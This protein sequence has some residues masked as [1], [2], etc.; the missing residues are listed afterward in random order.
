MS[1]GRGLTSDQLSG[2][3]TELRG[4]VLDPPDPEFNQRRVPFNAMY[5][6]RPDL[7]VRP[8]GT[9]DVAAAVRYAR[10]HDLEVVV[11]GGGHSVGGLS[12]AD[13]GMVIDL[14]TMHAVDVDPGVRLARVQGGAVLGELDRETQLF[15]LAVPVGVVSQTGVAGL[16]LGGGYGWLRRKHGLACDSLVSAQ[17]VCADG[18]VRT[19]SAEVNPDLFWAIRGGGGNFGVVTS[20]TFELHPV[21]PIVAFA[22]VFYPVEAAAEVLHGYRAYFTDA[23]DEVT[24]EALSITF[25]ADPSLPESVHDRQCLVVGAVYAGAVEEGVA[26]LRPLRELAEPLADI[27]QPMPFTAVQSAFDGLFPRGQIRAYWKAAY[28]ATLEDDVIEI[29]ARASAERP[30]PLTFVDTYAMGGAIARVGADDTAFA[31]RSAPYMVS[32]HGNWSAANDDEANI[33]WVR[34][35]WAKVDA[36]GVGSTYL[37]FSGADDADPSRAAVGFGSNLERLAR[38][39]AQ[40]DPENLFH[41]NNNIAPSGD[42]S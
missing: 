29:V 3:R 18:E 13:G 7:V 41:R 2:F 11:R 24:A 16:P 22:G 40:Y 4:A 27:S 36:L 38:V 14:S 9:A 32:V 26:V 25:P 21:G 17:V 6:D 12:T 42:G 10:E 28:V 31:E 30:S 39:K 23:R 1:V 19:A 5:E 33:A 20:F 37:N 34:D 8:T 35:V 15:G